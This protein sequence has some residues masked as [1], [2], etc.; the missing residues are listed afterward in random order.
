MSEAISAQ[1]LVTLAEDLND[2]LRVQTLPV[3]MKLFEDLDAM[4]AVPG[5]RTPTDGKRF[6]TCQLVT[7]AR[8]AG[9]TLGIVSDNLLPRANCGAVPGLNPIGPEYLS[10]EKMSGVWFKDRNEGPA[11]PGAD[12]A[13]GS[14]PL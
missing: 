1:E 2:L 5:L 8:V 4:K 12:A 10:G 6:G 3:G 7:Q 13:G 9:F 14:R 11:A